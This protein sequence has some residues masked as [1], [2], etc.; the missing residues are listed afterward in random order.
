M[1]VDETKDRV[2]IADLDQE[3]AEIESS[4]HPERIIFVPDVERKLHSIPRAVLLESDRE[5]AQNSQMVLCSAQKSQCMLQTLEK[6][7][8]GLEQAIERPA[9][10]HVADDM[11]MDIL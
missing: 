4:T 11:E 6:R 2:Y 7:R 10:D 1:Q 9:H 3:L 8:D 5:H